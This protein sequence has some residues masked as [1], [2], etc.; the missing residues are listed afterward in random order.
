M[1]SN[2]QNVYCLDSSNNI[3]KP[4]FESIPMFV[5]ILLCPFFHLRPFLSFHIIIIIIRYLKKIYCFDKNSFPDEYFDVI[6]TCEEH[7][8]FYF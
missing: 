4:I 3:I 6:E 2:V 7:Y 5:K 1:K 8:V